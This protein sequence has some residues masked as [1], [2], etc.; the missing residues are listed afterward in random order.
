MIKN[1]QGTSFFYIQEGPKYCPFSFNSFDT[2][3]GDLAPHNK[4]R[5]IACFE[6]GP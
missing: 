4:Q 5:L 6:R 3:C 1:G 2:L